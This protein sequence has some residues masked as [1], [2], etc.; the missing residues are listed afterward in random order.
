MSKFIGT[1]KE[2][3]LLFILIGAASALIDYARIA[4]GEIPVFCIKHYNK[5]T[6]IESFRGLFY[7]A[8][9][10]V[11]ISTEEKLVDS[12]DIKYEVFTKE[13]EV[14][15]QFK[16]QDFDYTLSITKQ[17]ECNSQSKLYFADTNTKL[18]TYC[19]EKIELKE[20]GRDEK[21]D[22][23]EYLRKDS[24]LMEDIVN[25][26]T[27]TGIDSDD[28]TLKFKKI[29]D[30][31]TT[32][33]IKMYRCHKKNINDIYILP[34]SEAKQDDFCEFKDD[35][36]DFLWYVE[37][38]VKENNEEPEKEVLY[39]NDEFRYEWD[40]KKSDRVFVVVP[41]IRG[42][43]EKKTPIR[44]ILD[45]NKHTIEELIERGLK[46]NKVEKEQQ[47]SGEE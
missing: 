32:D 8:S 22:L 42:R 17:E 36:Y 15:Q 10:K 29:D 25:R 19:I 45:S 44:E 21:K 6:K 33:A 26:M 2:L 46:I 27:Y 20:A 41:G 5:T 31:L 35:D 30:S 14:P 40:E 1:I 43:D 38:E 12:T 28:S 16:E 4:G 37:E 11:H 3:I 24:T 23:I 9:R 47:T 34:E 39:E 13:I 18:Y 7:Q